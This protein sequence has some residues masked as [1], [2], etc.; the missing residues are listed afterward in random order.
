MNVNNIKIA[1]DGGA[2]TGK[3]TVAELVAKKLNIKLINSGE[4][5]RIVTEAW[6]H[7]KNIEEVKSLENKSDIKHVLDFLRLRETTIFQFMTNDNFW[8]PHFKKEA[9]HTK[10]ISDNVSAVSAVLEVRQFVTEI[11]KKVVKETPSVIM[12]GRDIGSV[13]MPQANYKFFITVSNKE[14]ARRRFEQYK[15]KNPN[16]TIEEVEKQIEERNKHDS[17]RQYAPL[18]KVNDAIEIISDGKT[19][20][21]V[22]EEIISHIK[23]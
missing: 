21:E 20:Q 18:I 15:L 22:C 12:E 10:E 11:L 17:T 3:S 4:I 8:N 1:I 14:A 9:L 5:Y 13:V 19:Q 6:L 2:A 16:I 23:K 7:F